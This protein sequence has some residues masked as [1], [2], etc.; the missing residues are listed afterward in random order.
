M[1]IN[2]DIDNIS[3][4]RILETLGEQFRRTR[5]AQG[6]TQAAVAERAGVSK[7]TLERIENGGSTQVSSWI[8]VLRVLGHLSALLAL[9]P[10]DELRP[11][12]MLRRQRI[13]KRVR[14]KK[15]EENETWTWEE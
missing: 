11:L 2:I 5:I 14:P 13:P 3:D 8:R 15:K 9:M 4:D 10:N 1:T 6:L 7:R 12:N